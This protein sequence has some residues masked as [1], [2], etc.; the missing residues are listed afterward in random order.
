MS[1]RSQNVGS[2]KKHKM[3]AKRKVYYLLCLRCNW[4]KKRQWRAKSPNPV[5]CPKCHSY[6]WNM[7]YVLNLK[8]NPKKK[9]S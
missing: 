8:K 1:L 5:Q 6:R 4:G 9:K 7:P 3:K 2:R